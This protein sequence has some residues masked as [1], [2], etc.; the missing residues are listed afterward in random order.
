MFNKLNV[1]VWKNVDV[2]C[3]GPE[4]TQGMAL[5]LRKSILSNKRGGGS[6]DVCSVVVGMREVRGAS[7]R[8]A[9]GA[10]ENS[11]SEL[12]FFRVNI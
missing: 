5:T 3:L 8:E 10:E 1:H 7:R 6:A 2:E 9:P 12:F 4:S 11:S